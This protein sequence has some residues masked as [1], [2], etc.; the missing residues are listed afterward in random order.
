MIKK[1]SVLGKILGISN[2]NKG[3]KFI[4]LFNKIAKERSHKMLRS[5]IR[6]KVLERISLRN[7]CTIPTVNYPIERWY[8]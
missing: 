8:H 2:K 3:L 6:K 5:I 1:L 4:K 7:Y